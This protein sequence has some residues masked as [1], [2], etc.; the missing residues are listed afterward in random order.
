MSIGLKLAY[1]G[2]HYCGWQVQNN[3]KS[4]QEA[5]QDAMEAAF[6]TRGTVTGCSRTDAG[7][8]A[9]GFVDGQLAVEADLLVSLIS[10]PE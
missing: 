4:V 10:K 5:L 3:G 8:H 1:V 6:G 7:V 2:T 9:K